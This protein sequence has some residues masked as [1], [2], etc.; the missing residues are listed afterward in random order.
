[1]MLLTRLIP[2]LLPDYIVQE[3]QRLL[4]EPGTSFSAYTGYID[5]VL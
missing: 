5:V 2:V 4:S 3:T 1:M